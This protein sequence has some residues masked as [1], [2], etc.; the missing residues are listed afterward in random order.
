MF[1]LI[2]SEASYLRSLKVAVDHFYSSEA[3]KQTLSQTEHHILFSNIKQVMVASSRFVMDLETRLGENVVLPQVGDIV[4]RHCPSFHSLY[5]PYVTNMMYQEA[6]I[7]QQ[8]QQNKNFVCS[9]KK[10]E[11]DSVCQ[12]QSLKSFLVL[13][14]Q[15]IT[16]IKLL[17]EVSVQLVCLEMLLDFGKVKREIN[18]FHPPSV[19]ST[20]H[21]QSLSGASRACETTG[22]GEHVQPQDVLHQCF[23]AYFQ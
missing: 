11:S 6:L 5:V 9:L 15:R 21:Q 12:R 10:L 16:R 18:V 13:P 3:L 1:E 2:G 22:N 4:L 20:R 8:M 7:T 14:F 17:L 19:C 23:P